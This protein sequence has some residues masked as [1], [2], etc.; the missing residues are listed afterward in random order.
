MFGDQL[1]KINSQKDQAFSIFTKAREKLLTAITAAQEYQRKN[2]VEVLKHEDEI[3]ELKYN[4]TEL[5]KH[6]QQMNQS[7]NKIDQI[8]NL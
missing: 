4:N 5:V 3:A 2:D 7:V 6:V 8:I 1:S